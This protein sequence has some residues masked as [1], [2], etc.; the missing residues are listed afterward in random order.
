M[1]AQRYPELVIGI[2]GAIGIDIEA[3]TTTLQEAL[4]SVGYRA[5]P[6]RITSE[7]ASELTNV[8]APSEQDFAAEASYKMAHA[9]ELCRRH[10]SP[11]TLMRFAIQAIR[12]YRASILSDHDKKSDIDDGYL[13]GEERVVPRTAYVIRQLKRPEEVE[14]LR[15]IYG[16]QFFLISANLY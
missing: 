14:F 9:S 8:P 5:V 6:I 7:I 16:K 11:E 2:A 12:R 13:R 3:I 10:Q 4:S 1:E 15:K